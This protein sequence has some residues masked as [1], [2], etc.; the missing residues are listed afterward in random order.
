M[1][2]YV[3]MFMGSNGDLGQTILCSCW[4]QAVKQCKILAK[5]SG[6]VLSTKGEDTLYECG[7][8]C[9]EDNARLLIGGLENPEEE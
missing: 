8:A 7:E 2:S 4:D 3:A 6:Y 5:Q 9:F 1:A